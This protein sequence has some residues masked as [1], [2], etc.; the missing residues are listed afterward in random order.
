MAQ[1]VLKGFPGFRLDKQTN[2]IQTITTDTI[3]FYDERVVALRWR[4][5]SP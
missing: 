1:P 5:L 3:L 2:E 4:C